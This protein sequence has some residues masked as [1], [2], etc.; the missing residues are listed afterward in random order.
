MQLL[1]E[2]HGGPDKHAPPGCRGSWQAFVFFFPTPRTKHRK[3]QMVGK[4][5]KKPLKVFFKEKDHG[6]KQEAKKAINFKHHC[7]GKSWRRPA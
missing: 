5:E 3:L 4:V 2:K 6:A 1:Q 7:W